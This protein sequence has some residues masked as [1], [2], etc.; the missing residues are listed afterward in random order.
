MP[1][2]IR[3]CSLIVPL[4]C[5]ALLVASATSAQDVVGSITDIKGAAQLKRDGQNLAV[6]LGMTVNAHDMLHTTSSGNLTIALTSGDH[7]MLGESSSIVVSYQPFANHI[8]DHFMIELLD[9][10]VRYTVERGA[11]GTIPAIEVKAPNAITVA[12]GTDFEVAYITGRTCPDSLRPCR[13]Y[14]DISVYKGMVEVSNPADPKTPPVQ[15]SQGY[16]TAVPCDLP[17]T[18]PAPLAMN[19]LAA[20]GYQ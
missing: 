11:L 18:S 4:I 1:G 12:H 19:E 6:I 15:I 17:P 13:E 5:L 14:T 9:G 3:N 16:G 20:P 7:L 2:S 10:H 8:H